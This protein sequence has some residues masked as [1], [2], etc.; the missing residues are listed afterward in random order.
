MCGMRLLGFRMHRALIEALICDQGA[1]PK[2]LR[3]LKSL[4]KDAERVQ[5]A[6]SGA[7]LLQRM[8]PNLCR[9]ILSWI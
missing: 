6:V 8:P 1:P 7:P 9:L 4:E 3:Y 5:N 2:T